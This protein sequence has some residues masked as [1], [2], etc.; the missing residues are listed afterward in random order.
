MT[1]HRILQA[2]TLLSAVLLPV[3]AF[4]STPLSLK[5]DQTQVM[6]MDAPPG[7]IVVG[8]PSIADITIEGNQ[9]FL[10]GRG[11]GTTNM[12]IF[13]SKGNVAYDFEVTVQDG[14]A[15]NNITM[16]SGSQMM[17]TYSCMPT[18]QVTLHVGDNSGYFGSVISAMGAKNG[19]AT[20]AKS[21]DG[22][23]TPSPQP[24][25]Q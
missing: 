13:D 6:T 8:N 3:A 17:Q 12:I 25:P 23:G 1:R 21:S 22:S 10:H 18:C 5:T 4:A 20:G 2:A 11:Y 16:I 9:L 7:N 24:P 14:G 19:A 15:N